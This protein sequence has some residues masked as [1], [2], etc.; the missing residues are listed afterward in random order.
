METPIATAFVR[1]RPMLDPEELAILEGLERDA[2]ALADGIAAF[3][4]NFPAN[5][6][7]LEETFD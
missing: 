5:L 1:I 7:Q 2:R 4:T 3:L 6:P